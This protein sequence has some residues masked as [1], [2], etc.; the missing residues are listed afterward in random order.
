MM[1]M[2][3]RVYRYP[4]DP[5]PQQLKLLHRYA[6][7]YRATYN[8]GW[9]IKNQAQTNW[10]WGRDRLIEQGH[11][12]EEANKKAPKGD[13]PSAFT[14]TTIFR[15]NR[16]LPLYGKMC[17]HM[18]S[19]TLYPWWQHVNE[20]MCCQAFVDLDRAWKNWQAGRAN[21]PKPKQSGKCKESFRT[22]GIKKLPDSR[23]VTIPGN[24]TNLRGGFT[25]RLHRPASS[26][27]R[28]LNRYADVKGSGIKGAT[29]AREGTR[30]FVSFNVSIPEPRAARPDKNQRAAGAIGV[31]LGVALMAATST[32]LNVAGTERR[33]HANPRHIDNAERALKRWQARAARRYAKGKSASGQSRGWHEAQ[34][35]VSRLHALVAARR[36]GYQHLLTKAL[37]TQFEHVVIEDLKVKNMT[38]S[39]KGTVEE[40]GRNVAQKSGLNREILRVGWGEIRRQLEYKSAWYG[41]KVTA[42]NPA[43]TSRTCS[44]CNHQDAGSRRSQS[45]FVC[46]S[47]GHADNADTNAAIQIR[48]RGLMNA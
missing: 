5:T 46:T 41:S 8:Y 2:T 23:H 34:R 42:V 24:K 37:V 45:E 11:T 20:N 30:W 17:A 18:P 32:P 3:T 13:V 14:L 10:T 4:L 43:Y 40:P 26:M 7:A 16:N 12:K 15:R 21:Y 25:I 35:H 29:F 27:L 36:R 28:T 9:G 39:A 38:K 31:D 19:R 1:N 33:E 44:N 6:E 47:C 22:Q 48:K